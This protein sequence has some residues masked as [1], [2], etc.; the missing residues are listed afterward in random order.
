MGMPRTNPFDPVYRIINTLTPAEKMAAMPAF[1]RAM[2]VELT[3]VCNFHC[4]MCP[5]GIGVQNRAKGYMSEEVFSLVLA[6]AAENKTPLRFILWGEPTLHP[7]WL[8]WFTRCVEQ[9]VPVH[10]N[11]NGSRIS[12][13]DMRRLV[14]VGVHSV[15]FSFQGVDRKS[16]SEMRNTDYFEELLGKVQRLHEIRGDASS[17]YIHVSTTITYEGPELVA[18][19]RARVETMTDKVTIGRTELGRFD[20]SKAKLKDEELAALERMRREDK[21]VRKHPRCPEAFDKLSVYWDG[22]VSVCCRDFEGTMLAGDIRENTLAEIWQS[23]TANE[24]RQALLRGEYDRFALCRVCW[25]YHGLQ[26]PGLQN[27]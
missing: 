6:Q 10:F 15:K 21:L 13:D 1:P 11:T 23:A 14:E 18:A 17:P 4:L 8:E 3:N 9:G 12:E 16:Y 25:D 26:T 20:M 24:Y 5:V 19:F 7:H 27:V 2:D 22:R